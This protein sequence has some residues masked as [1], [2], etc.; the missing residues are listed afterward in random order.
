MEDY[1]DDDDI[2]DEMD[3]DSVKEDAI[4]KFKLSREFRDMQKKAKLY[5]Q[6]ENHP[7]ENDNGATCKFLSPWSHANMYV[8]QRIKSFHSSE[9]GLLTMGR[10]GRRPSVRNALQNPLKTQE[11]Y[12]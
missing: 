10:G 4:K 2:A 12:T 11:K 6:L 8:M 9:E 5:A 3:E 7:E 1:V